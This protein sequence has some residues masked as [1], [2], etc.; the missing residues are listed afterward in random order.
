V[1]AGVGFTVIDDGMVD[2]IAI[3][4]DAHRSSLTG[5]AVDGVTGERR[6]METVTATSAGFDGC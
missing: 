3:G 5:G 2:M 1:S 6:G 4:T